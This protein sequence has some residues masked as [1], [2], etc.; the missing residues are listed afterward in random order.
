MTMQH[1]AS[2][3]PSITNGNGSATVDLSRQPLRVAPDQGEV[4]QTFQTPITFDEAAELICQAAKAD[5]ERTDIGIGDLST[6][7]FGPAPDGCAAIAPFPIAGR[8]RAEPAPLRSTAFGHLCTRIGAPAAYLRNLPAKF[9]IALVNHG[10]R[11]LDEK[12]ATARLAGGEVRALASDRYAPL[13][14]G[15]VLDTTRRTLV[16]SGM[17]SDVRVRSIATG[18]STGL[19]LTL[20]GDAIEIH[21]SRQVGDIVEYGLDLLNGEVCNRAVSINAVTYRLI[22]LNGMRRGDTSASARLRHV[23][24]PERL[25]EAFKDAVPAVVANARGFAQ[26]M[27]GAVDRMVDDLLDEV[28]GLGAFG[29]TRGE[30]QDVARDVMADRGLALPSDTKAWAETLAGVTGI[31]VY[32]VANAVTHQAQTRSVDRRLDMEEAGGRYMMRRVG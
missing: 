5:G 31:S 6:W 32:D 1:E 22:C 7:V 11:S 15:I 27:Q 20:P 26:A 10:M 8:D 23:G 13:D 2:A 19:R 24:D 16:E 12:A 17:L 9:Q 28:E 18:V 4:W 30:R 3:S 21:R 25:R 29:L 14:H